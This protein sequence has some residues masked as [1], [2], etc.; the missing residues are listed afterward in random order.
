MDTEWK[1]KPRWGKVEFTRNMYEV[2]IGNGLLRLI[3]DEHPY[4]PGKFKA[5]VNGAT[6]IGTPDSFDSIQE[7][8]EFIEA[9]VVLYL[10]SMVSEL[11]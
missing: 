8:Q 6:P 4:K 2:K 10:R 9:R 3:V 5:Q 7:A 1:S 11:T